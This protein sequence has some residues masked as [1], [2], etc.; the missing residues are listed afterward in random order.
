MRF[1]VSFPIKVMGKDTPEFHQAVAAIFSRHAAP[2]ESLPVKRNSSSGGQFISL[3]VTIVA[4]SREQLDALYLELT[5]C[6][7][8][9]VTL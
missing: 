9:L 2:Y 1:P 5:S 8:V 3:T 4:Q 7:H 6:E